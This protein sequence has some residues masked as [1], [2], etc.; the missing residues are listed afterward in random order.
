VSEFTTE[1]QATP[2]PTIAGSASHSSG[3]ATIRLDSSAATSVPASTKRSREKRACQR[4]K[5]NAAMTAPMP[6]HESITV[7]VPGPPPCSSRAT[8]GSSETSAAVCRKNRKARSSTARSRIDC[9]VNTTPARIAP[10][11]RS[12]G[13]VLACGSQRQRRISTMA[14]AASTTLHTNTAAV[15]RPASSTPAN[16]GPTTRE[17]FIATLLS[18]SAGA[19]CARGTT[20]G[21]IAANTGSR[22]ARPTPLLNVSSSSSGAVS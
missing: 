17:R 3:T 14:A 19:S 5:T 21:M 6:M 13:N 8:S 1:S 22:I 16:M 2:M 7:N 11:K 15:P 9:S 4:G 10:T 12:P 18:A 20:C